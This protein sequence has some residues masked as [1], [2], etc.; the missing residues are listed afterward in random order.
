MKLFFAKARGFGEQA[1]R[2]CGHRFLVLALVL[3]LSAGSVL[4]VPVFAADSAESTPAAATEEDPL[5]STAEI[6]PGRLILNNVKAMESATK[7]VLSD[8]PGEIHPLYSVS[9]QADDQSVVLCVPQGT[10]AAEAV[11]LAGITLGEEDYLS[12]PNSRFVTEGLTVAITRVGYREY[13]KTFSISYKTETKYTADLRQG[14]SKVQRAG[15]AGVRTVTYRE[16]VENGKVVSTETVKEEVTKQPV[17]KIILK[18]TKVGKIVSEAPMN[19]ELDSIGHPVKYLKKLTGK[20]TAYTSDR[21]DSGGTT[22]LG[23][24]T[25]VG[26]VAVDP[27]VIPYGTKLWIVSPDGKQVYG[28][29][30]AGDTGGAVRSGKVLVDLYFDTYGECSKFGRRTMDVYIIG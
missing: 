21:G 10:T 6:D 17:N 14:A 3:A 15:S 29:A 1:V 12:V 8:Y 22:A 25:Q 20:A 19:I 26:V 30:V 27:R 4:S 5:S 7:V 23:W 28:Y 16:R 13:T 2:L 9:V 11:T 18:G 24:K